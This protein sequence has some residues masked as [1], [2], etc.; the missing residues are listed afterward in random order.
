MEAIHNSSNNNR[1]MDSNS[2]AD[3]NNLNH[4]YSRRNF[5]DREWD[6]LQGRILRIRTASYHELAKNLEE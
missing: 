2:M 1:D 3:S 6:L 4:N 5:R